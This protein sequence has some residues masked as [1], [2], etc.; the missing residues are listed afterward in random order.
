M[1]STDSISSDA[2]EAICEKLIQQF[3]V[4]HGSLKGVVSLKHC[5]QLSI[6]DHCF[7]V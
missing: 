7:L 4:L 2:Y 5:T 3:K 1:T 6:V